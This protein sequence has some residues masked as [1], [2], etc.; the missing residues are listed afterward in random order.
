MAHIK[1]FFFLL[2]LMIG[3]GAIVYTI[4]VKRAFERPFLKPFLLFLVFNNIINLMNLTSEYGCANLLGFCHAYLYKAFP[5]ILGPVARLA[6]FGIL[7]ALVGMIWGLRER[8]LPKGVKIG[9]VSATVLLSLSYTLFGVLYPRGF[10]VRWLFRGQRVVFMLGVYLS[11][12]LLFFLFV[13]ARKSGKTPSSHA[14]QAFAVFY[15]AAYMVFLLSYRLP[16]DVQ[17]V[18]NVVTLLAFNVYPFFWFKRWFFP[19]LSEEEGREPDALALDRLCR[20]AGLTPRE[21]ELANLILKGQSNAEIAKALFLSPHTVKNHITNLFYKAGV[22]NRMQLLQRFRSARARL[23]R[24]FAL[25]GGLKGRES[26]PDREIPA[27]R[28][29]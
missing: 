14:V 17:F 1:I 2:S 25:A 5:L 29:H 13:S 8:P 11:L 16:L 21:C 18:P 19:S 22:K 27:V 10:P 24:D 26:M 7:F 28:S 12:G 20:D 6:Q 3:I 9:F 15:L 23:G 4:L